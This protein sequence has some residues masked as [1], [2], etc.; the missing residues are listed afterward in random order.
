MAIK[1]RVPGFRFNDLQ[2][3]I[4]NMNQSKSRFDFIPKVNIVKNS[5]SY[6]LDIEL[7]GIQKEDI[8]ISLKN[9]QLIISGEKR[10]RDSENEYIKIETNYGK[11]ERIFNIEEKLFNYEEITSTFNNGILEITLPLLEIKEKVEKLIEIK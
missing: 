4:N 6:I 7:P 3:I 8:S 11:F 1:N 5:N 2:D 10:I 9:N